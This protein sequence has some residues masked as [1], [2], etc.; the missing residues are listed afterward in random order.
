[1]R[2]FLRQILICPHCRGEFQTLAFNKDK[3]EIIDGILC[4]NSCSKV[5]PVINSIPRI[6]EGALDKSPG[7]LSR[8]NKELGALPIKIPVAGADL[9]T[10]IDSLTQES[11]GFQWSRF[12]EMSC[13]FKENFLNYIYPQEPSFFKGKTGL[14]VGCG[15]GRHIYNAAQFGAEMVGMDFSRAIDSTR[16]NTR[17]LKNVHLVQADIYRMPFKNNVFDFAYSI[18]VLHH[19]SGPE[20][21]FRAF[22][23]L[24]KPKGV[25]L[26]WVYSD[27]RKFTILLLELFRHITTKMP[28]SI[29]KSI[30]FLLAGG[31]WIFL[32]LPYKSLKRIP[33][34]DKL[35]SKVLFPRI[36]LYTQYPFQVSYADWFDRLAAPVR[37]YYNEDGLRAWFQRANLINIKISPTG[38]Y[39]LRGYGEKPDV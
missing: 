12:S 31:E 21:G 35:L 10:R 38:L 32:V 11:F 17:H 39:G 15:F 16:K 24:I 26:V 4:C 19:L 6:L 37:F 1:M 36:K 28:H 34:F 18:G 33:A 22:M 20:A 14:D 3:E 30:C 27:K 13:D 9:Q 29:L 7:F 8:F 23:P 2:E 5:Y 25:A